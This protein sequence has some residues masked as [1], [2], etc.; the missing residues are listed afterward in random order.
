MAI[1]TFA[2]KIE[3]NLIATNFHLRISEAPIDQDGRRSSLGHPLEI[4]SDNLLNV[5]S[6]ALSNDSYLC[7]M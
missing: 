3:G 2:I 6:Y 4:A 7:P 1:N 5:D